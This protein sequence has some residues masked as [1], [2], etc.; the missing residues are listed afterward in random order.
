M[1]DKHDGTPV[2]SI[3]VVTHNNSGEIGD[4]LRA[5]FNAIRAHSA[6]ILVVDNAS[7]DGTPD[8]I[9]REEWPV[10][11]VTLEKNVGFAKAVNSAFNRC[12]GRYI[13]LVNS[14]AF[15]DPGCI[16]RL[17]QALEKR[18]RVGIVG[19]RLRYP[20]GRL[21]PSAGTFPSL[22]G[23]LWVAL[24][25]HRIPGLSRLG[26]GFLADQS[27]YRRP[28]RVDWVSGAVCAARKEVG[29]LPTSYFM[30]G[31]D[32]QWAWECSRMGL[33]VW[34][35]PSA[36][37]VHVGRASV[38]R[39]QD[40]GFAQRQRA[41]FELAWFSRRGSLAQLAARFV[42]LVHALVRLAAYGPLTMVQSRRDARASE[43]AVLLQA[44]LATHRDSYDD[45]DLAR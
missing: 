25:M 34:L 45:S 31:E 39:S 22:L 12:R 44:A 33:E 13:A 24:F 20:S 40:L 30:Y 29:R 27:L 38:D 7:T 6:E 26:I 3:V 18:P 41:Q 5:V 15:P 10:D 21:Q 36:T 19:A 35:E 1:A 28:R 14:D 16:D 4:C 11:M 32:V 43:Y 9:A 42:L 37:A 17:V 2:V 8:L 23:G